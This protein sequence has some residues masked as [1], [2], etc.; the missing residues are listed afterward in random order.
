MIATKLGITIAA[1]AIALAVSA[2]AAQAAPIV[3]VP[4]API[5]HIVEPAL[6]PTTLELGNLPLANW[7]LNTAA[8]QNQSSA[9]TVFSVKPL[10]LLP[11][12]IKPLFG[13]FASLNLNACIAGVGLHVGPYGTV[14]ATISRTC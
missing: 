8:S 7:W 3:S 14:S 1:S 5:T 13:W 12:F 10:A 2:P 9:T 4:A 11:G 6:T